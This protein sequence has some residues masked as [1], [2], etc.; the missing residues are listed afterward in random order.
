MINHDNV[1]KAHQAKGYASLTTQQKELFDRVYS[2]HWHGMGTEM[3]QRYTA[4]HI[5]DIKWDAQLRC[6]KVFFNDGN[7]WHYEQ[8]GDWY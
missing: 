8:N 2:R 7:W 6:I 3:R 1:T 5:K 4:D